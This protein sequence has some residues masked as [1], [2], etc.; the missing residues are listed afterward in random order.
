ML[1]DVDQE[2]IQEERH[3]ADFMLA[4]DG[5]DPGR[6][7]MR[8]RT[9][10]EETNHT[11]RII[12][13]DRDRPALSQKARRPSPAGPDHWPRTEADFER[14]RPLPLESRPV[15]QVDTLIDHR[16]RALQRLRAVH[17]LAT[18]CLR[19]LTERLPGRDE[20]ASP[21]AESKAENGPSGGGDAPTEGGVGFIDIG[22]Q[23]LE[24]G[25]SADVEALEVEVESVLH[26]DQKTGNRVRP[27][28]ERAEERR[29]LAVE[30]TS[31]PLHLRA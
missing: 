4:R 28:L 5:G 8:P 21:L 30:Q 17:D 1:S 18:A 29:P 20:L 23:S 9:G 22:C 19:E 26:Q 2:A 7:D 11:R 13:V 27:A 15:G 6:S 3:V 16:Q 24:S 31:L 14:L 25:R 10:G 12:V